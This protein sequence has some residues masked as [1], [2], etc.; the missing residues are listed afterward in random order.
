[1]GIE[2]L[3]EALQSSGFAF[4]VVTHDRYFLENVANEVV[5]LNRI[6]ADGLLRVKGDYS[7]FLEAKDEYLRAQG[8]LQESLANRVR[9]EIE[10]LRRGPKARA[11]KA[12]ARIVKANEMI[13]QLAVLNE[14]SRTADAKIDFTATNR[15]TKDLIE[16]RGVA[17]AGGERTLF[18]G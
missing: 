6:Y 9:T 1:A 16:L 17:C 10:W 4:V 13:D 8:K 5:E 12:K 7:R 2:W 15:Q 3:E 11:T 14:R 18:E